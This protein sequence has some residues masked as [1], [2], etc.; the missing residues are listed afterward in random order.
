MP[1]QDLILWMGQYAGKHR[2]KQGYMVRDKLQHALAL[3][4]RAW[5]FSR[6]KLLRHLARRR[7][8]FAVS[9]P[10]AFLMHEPVQHFNFIGPWEASGGNK[11]AAGEVLEL[12][13]S[14]L[15]TGTPIFLKSPRIIFSPNRSLRQKALLLLGGKPL[16]IGA[17][18]WRLISGRFLP[19]PPEALAAEG[20]S[21][22]LP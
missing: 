10:Y 13:F 11:K 19:L 1:F 20:K 18:G 14:R 2:F 16:C 3:D 6:R 9:S 15:G 12:L 21:I 8:L 7:E 17:R 5:H 4:E 22:S